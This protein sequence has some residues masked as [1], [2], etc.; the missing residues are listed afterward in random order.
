MRITFVAT[1]LN[2]EKG[3]SNPDLHL[4]IKTLHQLGHDIKLITVFSE[5]NKLPES[6]PASVNEEK[7]F[8]K[9]QINIQKQ[10][11]KILKKYAPETDIF[12][13]EG[14]FLYGGGLYRL[15]GG[16]VPILAFFNRE[17]VSWPP[18]S[19]RPWLK[20]KQTTRFWLEK[21][22]GARLANRLDFFIF[23]SPQMQANYFAFGLK[24][25]ASMAM[26]D[27]VDMAETSYWAEK[28]PPKKISRIH[29]IFCAGRLVP[30]KRFDLV[31]RAVAKLKDKYK[32]NLIVGGSGP[33][34]E[35][36]KKTAAACGV[37]EIISF[38]GW[39]GRAELMRNFQECEI[40]ITPEWRPDI[41][42][43][44]LLEAMALKT[45]CLVPAD[46]AFAWITGDGAITFRPDN[47]DDLAKQIARL[48]D[49]RELA[50]SLG[51]AGQKRAE[52]L[53]AKNLA[54]QLEN[55][56][57]QAVKAV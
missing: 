22:I 8:P 26:P 30:E 6:L 33:N 56:L 23:T 21:N 12:H 52:M 3:G 17:L 47:I 35:N 53:D 32:I 50:Q 51:R 40:C 15:F 1:K 39:L 20:L 44:Q 29:K 2:L 10:I 4:K 49:D 14:H 37:E 46:T 55:I 42:S 38:P 34:L 24:P 54:G 5:L 36:L 41:S 48:I 7:I 16:Q 45:P 18:F 31:I 19:N 28:N 9:S 25:G 11:F 57:R 27:F 43:V 13:L